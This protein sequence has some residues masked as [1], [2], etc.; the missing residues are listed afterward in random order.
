MHKLQQVISLDFVIVGA[1]PAGSGIIMKLLKAYESDAHLQQRIGI[2]E[3]SSDLMV[4]S[5]TNYKVNSD[6]YSDV[7]LECLKDNFF[8]SSLFSDEI[9]DIKKY[10]GKCIPL[11]K[12]KSYFHKLSAALKLKIQAHSQFNLYLNTIVAKVIQRG[13]GDFEIHTNSTVIIAKK[14]I[15][16]SGGTPISIDNTLRF[17]NQFDLNIYSDKLIHSDAILNVDYFSRFK[18][19]FTSKSKIVILGGS[20]SAFSVAHFLLNNVTE[21]NY[22]ENQIQIWANAE[23]KVYF[24]S[25]EEALETG[26]S[27]FTS[28]DV[29]SVTNKVF[30][31]AGLRMDGRS[32]YMQMIGLSE[33][34]LE[35]RISF[36]LLSNNIEVLKRELSFADSIVLA[37]GYK[38]N[39]PTFYNESNEPI[40]FNGMHSKHWVDAT[41]NVIDENGNPIPNLY[42][43]GL[44]TGFI[45]SGKLGGESSFHGQTNGI[46]YYQNA[47]ADLVFNELHYENITNMR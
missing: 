19:K 34:E 39:M 8:D 16:A 27:N 9:D 32:L 44:A 6:T 24:N 14:L 15:I 1:G 11:Y 43:I 36:K 12:L 21:V 20:H 13:N 45:P 33:S 42:A 29:C 30:R 37:L 35:T 5:I 40:L 2:I 7:F 38:F 17:S 26:Y 18:K 22:N 3:K 10:S 46:W 47:I 23:P 25:K 41:C 31:L 28:L 4:G